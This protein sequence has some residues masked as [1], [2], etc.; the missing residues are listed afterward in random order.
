S[1]ASAMCVALA[2]CWNDVE[3]SCFR[4]KNV[5]I[6][7]LTHC[8]R[9]GVTRPVLL[10][11]CCQLLAISECCVKRVLGSCTPTL[12]VKLDCCLMTLISGIASRSTIVLGRGSC[13]SRVGLARATCAEELQKTHRKHERLERRSAPLNGSAPVLH[14]TGSICTLKVLTNHSSAWS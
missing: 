11:N 5:A 1:G 4:A 6:I 7:R 3:S 10:P 12:D 14:S 2:T 9:I 8:S 13:R